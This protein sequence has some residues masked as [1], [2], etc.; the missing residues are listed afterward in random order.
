MIDRLRLVRTFSAENCFVSVLPFSC[1]SGGRYLT[2]F[3]TRFIMHFLWLHHASPSHH[4][5]ASN[6]T[7]LYKSHI[8]SLCNAHRKA[9]PPPLSHPFYVFSQTLYDVFF[10][11]SKGSCCTRIQTVGKIIVYPSFNILECGEDTLKIIVIIVIIII[12]A[13]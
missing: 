11:Q 5:I 10:P 1:S 4:S 6:P 12:L 13:S 3:P 8:S 9:P 2:D 7:C